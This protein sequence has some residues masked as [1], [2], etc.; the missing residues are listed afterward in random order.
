[1]SASDKQSWPQ[2]PEGLTDWEAAF[3]DPSKG[4]IALITQAKSPTAL[5]Q[6]TIVVIEKL[7]TRQN[8]PTEVERFSAELNQMIPDD[9]QEEDLPGIAAAVTGILRQ[10]KDDRI[11]K[12]VKFAK[13][14]EAGGSDGGRRE[15]C[16][17][18]G[19]DGASCLHLAH[20]RAS[21]P[22]R[23]GTGVSLY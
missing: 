1:M 13:D 19:G 16:I 17:R 14:Q 5:R 23:R 2:T 7:Y 21:P 3:E 10:I 18:R 11:Q 6:S 15:D 12:A 8:D 20:R 4:F 22:H 9:A